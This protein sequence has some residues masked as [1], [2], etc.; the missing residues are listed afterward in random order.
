MSRSKK[1]F[2]KSLLLHNHQAIVNTPCLKK[3]QLTATNGN[4]NKHANVIVNPCGV[5]M[6]PWR[7]SFVEI[8][9]VI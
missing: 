5:E 8:S 2:F 1:G 3:V 9:A 6:A 4:K 7:G